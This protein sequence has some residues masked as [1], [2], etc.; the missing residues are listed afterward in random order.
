MEIIFERYHS[1]HS[2]DTKQT[3]NKHLNEIAIKG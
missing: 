1:M 2:I 3:Y